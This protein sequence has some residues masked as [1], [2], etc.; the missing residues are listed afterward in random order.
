MS[1]TARLCV[2]CFLL[3][4]CAGLLGCSP[5][6]N[7]ASPTPE[8]MSRFRVPADGSVITIDT[9]SKFDMQYFCIIAEGTFQD[10]ANP[11]Q[12]ADA[13]NEQDGSGNWSF[14][15]SLRIGGNSP[16]G[17]FFN[18]TSTRSHRFYGA[19]NL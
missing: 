17:A 18:E 12:S 15:P 10:Q 11:N 6:A 14:V 1:P 13:C 7:G 5:Q 19:R 2:I 16:C 9:P 3:C 4:S 8:L